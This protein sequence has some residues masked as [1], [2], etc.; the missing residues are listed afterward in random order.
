MNSTQAGGRSLSAF[1]RRQET[2]QGTSGIAVHPE[3]E[4]DGPSHHLA[5]RSRA[6]SQRSI[7]PGEQCLE[8]APTD[9]LRRCNRSARVGPVLSSSLNHLRVRPKGAIVN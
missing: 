9:A 1:R 8:T 3:P 2:D 4:S 5:G 6:K 7:S